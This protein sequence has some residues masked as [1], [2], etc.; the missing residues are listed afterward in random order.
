M[1]KKSA[2]PGFDPISLPELSTQARAAVKTAFDSMSAWRNEIATA[3]ETNSKQVLDKMAKAAAALGWPEQIVD[4]ARA[5]IQSINAMQIKT[6][7]HIM[8]AWEEQLKSPNPTGA[9]PSAMLSKLQSMP[10]FGPGGEWP[11]ADALQAAA[12][13]PLALWIEFAKQWQTFWTDSMT[14]ANRS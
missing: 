8:G 3:G 13:A 4:A 2:A 7:D 12:T 11:N 9:S 1:Q 5:Q 10:G 6:M 14:K